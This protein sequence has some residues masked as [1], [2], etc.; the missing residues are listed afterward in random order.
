MGFLFCTADCLPGWQYPTGREQRP[1]EAPGLPEPGVLCFLL[2]PPLAKG[3][4]F[5][6]GLKSFKSIL[7]YILI[8]TVRFVKYMKVSFVNESINRFGSVV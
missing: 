4:P 2:S 8:T 5:Q 6:A 1:H 3:Q 7:R